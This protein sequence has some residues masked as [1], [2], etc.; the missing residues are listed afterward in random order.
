MTGDWPG[1]PPR[2][3]GSCA[4][5]SQ[6]CARTCG[7]VHGAS[8]ML[9]PHGSWLFTCPAFKHLATENLR[10]TSVDKLAMPVGISCSR[11]LEIRTPPCLGAGQAAASHLHQDVLVPVPHRSCC[12]STPPASAPAPG[13]EKCWQIDREHNA[14]LR[15]PNPKPSTAPQLLLI[16]TTSV[17][18]DAWGSR[19]GRTVLTVFVA[20]VR[21]CQLAL[22]L[23]SQPRLS[24]PCTTAEEPAFSRRKQE[25]GGGARGKP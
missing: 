4:C 14:A 15:N 1:S 9:C 5:T 8:P 23:V 7:H 2:S 20:Q 22:A 11:F 17:S 18:T 16:Y 19:A 24:S 3:S 12:W 13:A 6:W 25:V 10:L 21:C